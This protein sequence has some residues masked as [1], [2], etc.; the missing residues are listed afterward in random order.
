[1]R[2][3]VMLVK[4]RLLL[5]RIRGKVSVIAHLLLSSRTPLEVE[6]DLSRNRSR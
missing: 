4:V 6:T 3:G 1:M 5:E 2:L